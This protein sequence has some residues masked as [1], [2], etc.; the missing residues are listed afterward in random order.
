MK[1]AE[2][3]P[4]IGFLPSITGLQSTVVNR[5]DHTTTKKKGTNKKRIIH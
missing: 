2:I 5:A 1:M 3:N 4:I